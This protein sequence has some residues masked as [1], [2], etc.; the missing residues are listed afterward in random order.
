MNVRECASCTHQQDELLRRLNSVRRP[1]PEGRRAGR[2]V[3]D[4][5]PSVDMGFLRI[6]KRFPGFGLILAS[7]QVHIPPTCGANAHRW[8]LVIFDLLS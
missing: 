5:A 8:V 6:F 4:D 1:Y 3:E 7:N 2:F